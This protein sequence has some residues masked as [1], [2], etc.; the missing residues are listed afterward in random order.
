MVKRKQ[1]SQVWDKRERERG[2]SITTT[3][4]TTL[5][6]QYTLPQLLNENEREREREK[7]REKEREREIVVN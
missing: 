1:V 6:G 2:G 4:C 5:T 3:Q 7:E